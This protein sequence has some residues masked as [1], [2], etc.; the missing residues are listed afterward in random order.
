[1]RP[2]DLM[3]SV[4]EGLG[5]TLGSLVM[6]LGFGAMLGKLV[7]ESGAAQRISSKLIHLFGSK[8]FNGP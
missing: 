6:I 5:S 2:A 1:M 7:A 4:E 3:K 8:T